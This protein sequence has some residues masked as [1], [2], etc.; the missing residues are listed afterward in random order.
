MA[1]TSKSQIHLSKPPSSRFL[2][3]SVNIY[4]AYVP[5]F[6]PY[7]IR[8]LNKHS[9]AAATRI[10]KSPVKRLDHGGDKLNRIMRCVK[11]SLF[12]GSVYGK[13]LQ[14][15]LVNPSNKVFF[16]AKFLMAD[17]IDLVHYF[18]YVCRI[19]IAG[20]ECAVY[21]TTFKPI[22]GLADAF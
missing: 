22:I 11:F 2:L 19:K 10:V 12:F 4:A 16:F 14:K 7:K 18:L 17:F 9:G 15:I 13:F 21:D 6:R 8:A 1:D 5:F 3:L 20:G